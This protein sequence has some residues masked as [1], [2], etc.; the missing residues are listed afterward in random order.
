MSFPKYLWGTPLNLFWLPEIPKNIIFQYF[1]QPMYHNPDLENQ[2]LGFFSQMKTKYDPKWIYFDNSN[3]VKSMVLESN[4]IVFIMFI[5]WM[6]VSH[7]SC[8]DQGLIKG[9]ILCFRNLYFYFWH[10]ESTSTAS[11]PRSC[12][13]SGTL[14]KSLLFWLAGEVSWLAVEVLSPCQ[15]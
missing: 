8:C 12:K 5:W 2:V 4:L 14:F 6:L 15:K 13:R 10:G 7:I 11:Q 3:Y 1:C 9:A